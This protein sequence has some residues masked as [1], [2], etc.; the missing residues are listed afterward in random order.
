MVVMAGPASRGSSCEPVGAR[1]GRH[2]LCCVN[3][4]VGIA[5]Q[6]IHHKS[7]GAHNLQP[8]TWPMTPQGHVHAP[9]ASPSPSL[10]QMRMA[11]LKLPQARV[12]PEGCQS[13]A[14]TSLASSA[15]C[16]GRDR[17]MGLLWSAAG[18]KS[19]TRAK[20]SPELLCWQQSTHTCSRPVTTL[21]PMCFDGHTTNQIRRGSKAVVYLMCCFQGGGSSPF[22]HV[23][24]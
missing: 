16:S 12:L 15:S 2:V 11:P 17:I 21:S 13:A 14:H 7:T 18:L 1:T 4:A 10:R 8:T 24:L 3:R 23:S 6:K 20:G 9:S 22:S 5:I 19:H